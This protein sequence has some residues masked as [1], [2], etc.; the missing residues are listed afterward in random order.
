VSIQWKGHALSCGRTDADPTFRVEDLRFFVHDLRLVNA[1]G[2]ETPVRLISDG[3]WQT[4]DVAL[5]DFAPDCTDKRDSHASIDLQLPEGQWSSLRFRI[6]VPFELNH[7][8]PATAEG[9]LAVGPMSWSWQAG[10]KFLKV[11]GHRGNAA[12]RVHLGASQCEGTFTH[13]T[14]CDRPNIP[15]ISVPWSGAVSLELTA[16]VDETKT[17]TAAMSCMGNSEPGCAH[18]YAALGLD[19]TTGAPASAQRAFLAQ[20]N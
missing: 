12:F 8:N 3:T 17:D 10:Y 15:E 2:Q 19:L 16:L 18:A 4:K 11:E 1:S 13:V 5:L 7:A 14:K 20:G 9:P 6:G